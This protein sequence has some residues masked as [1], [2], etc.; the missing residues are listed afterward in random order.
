VKNSYSILF[1]I[2][3]LLPFIALFFFLCLYLLVV[4]RSIL[5]K[6][7]SSKLLKKVKYI[8]PILNKISINKDEEFKPKKLD[9]VKNYFIHLINLFLWFFKET[10]TAQ[11]LSDSFAVIINFYVEK[12]IFLFYIDI[13]T[14]AFQS[15]GCKE[16]P[17]GMWTLVASPNIFCFQ[18]GWWFLVPISILSIIIFGLGTIIYF[19]FLMIG[20]VKL[21]NRSFFKKINQISLQTFKKRAF[22]WQLTILIRKAM[23][24]ILRV[25]FAP[26]SMMAF[27]ITISFFATLLQFHYV[28]Y[29]KKLQ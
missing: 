15:F 5:V 9:A 22:F 26:I 20:S 2:K 8:T 21:K 19:I 17:N 16:Q 4:L 13:M 1:G 11:E 14:T 28:P 27:G 18:G 10:S 12:V 24:S 3:I 6:F 25:F 29:R 23:F 7:I